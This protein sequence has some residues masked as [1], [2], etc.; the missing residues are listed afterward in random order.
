MKKLLIT[1]SVLM[2][3][4]GIVMIGGGLL[5]IAVIYQN[6][7]QEKIVTPDDAS[8]PNVPVRGPFTLK[9]QADIIKQHTLRMTN[10]QVFAEMPRQ[11][12]KLDANGNPV[13]GNDGKPVMVANTSR[14]IWITA[15]TLTT[16][17]H[18]ESSHMQSRVLHLSSIGFHF[19]RNHFTLCLNVKGNLKAARQLRWHEIQRRR[20]ARAGK[21]LPPTL[22]LCPPEYQFGARSATSS[23]QKVRLSNNAPTKYLSRDI[24]F[25]RKNK[26]SRWIKKPAPR[27]CAEAGYRHDEGRRDHDRFG[28]L[29]TNCGTLRSAH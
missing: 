2:I 20:K 17:L 4:V 6:V 23:V 28:K 24:L 21:I 16:A 3:V 22:F 8:I 7:I 29:R 10:G 11:V 25:L 14:D 18:L 15:T 5:G 1:S 9:A 26:G 27:S 12:P 19:N 13:L